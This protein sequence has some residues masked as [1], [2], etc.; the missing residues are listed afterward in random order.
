MTQIWSADFKI[1]LLIKTSGAGFVNIREKPSTQSGEIGKARDGDTFEMVS[2][3][4]DWYEIKLNNESNGFI[5]EEFA[6][7][8]EIN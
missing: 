4:S 7:I 8:K 2:R 6:Q 5:S 1:N 3:E